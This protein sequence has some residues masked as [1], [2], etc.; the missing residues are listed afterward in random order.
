METNN[1]SPTQCKARRQ[2]KRKTTY[3]E[4]RGGNLANRLYATHL[5]RPYEGRGAG[6]G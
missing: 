5:P 1:I 3:L 6:V 2:Y 4:P